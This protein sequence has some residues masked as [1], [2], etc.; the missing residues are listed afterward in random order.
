[1]KKVLI[2]IFI[3]IVGLYIAVGF[4][5]LK[6]RN[7]I[8]GATILTT[9]TTDTIGTFRTNVNTSLT[10]L[11]NS[12]TGVATTW[13]GSSSLLYASSTFNKVGIGNL[14]PSS[15]L[16]ITGDLYVTSSSTI[17]GAL[18][19]LS[20]LLVNSTSTLAST[21]HTGVLKLLSDGVINTSGQIG[22]QSA[23]GTLITSGNGQVYAI[24]STSTPVSFQV[25]GPQRQSVYIP[26]AMTFKKVVCVLSDASGAKVDFNFTIANDPTASTT[27]TN[28]FNLTQN[29][30]STTGQQYTSS[31]IATVP[32]GNYINL[33][34]TSNTS[35]TPDA[36]KSYSHIE[37]IGQKLP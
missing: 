16:H 5:Y 15:T 2:I 36:T 21:T 7:D 30:N 37:F 24:H 9:A 28:L 31:S 35:S 27:A 12:I 10:N 19:A 18:K 32:A 25:A 14:S 3:L 26:F 8:L 29:C 22:F 34:F 13:I 33:V 11:N 17:T 1:M 20:T 23:S 4:S 6:N